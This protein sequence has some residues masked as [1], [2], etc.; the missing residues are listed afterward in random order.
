ML[1]PKAEL[2]VHLEGTA[3]PALIRR[4]AE[5]N[6]LE[7]PAGVLAA[8]DRFAYTDFLDFLDTYDRAASV[9]RSAADYRDITYEYLSGCAL[10]GALYVELIASPDHARMVGLSD[11]E[12]LEGIARGIDDALKNADVALYEAKRGGRDRFALA[13]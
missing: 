1:I 13:A 5:R 7:L 6:G 10:E 11:E 8:P 12:H 3:P 2:H 4:L 9:I